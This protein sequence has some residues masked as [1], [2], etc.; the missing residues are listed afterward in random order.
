MIPPEWL[1]SGHLRIEVSQGAAG[2]WIQIRGEVDLVNHHHLQDM[3]FALDFLATDDICLDLRRLTFCD[4]AGCQHLLSFVRRAHS[5]GREVSILGA[6]RS[7]V[8][9]LSVIAAGDTLTFR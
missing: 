3:L 4:T 9:M 1:A 8:A 5:A 7:V 2:A 6:S